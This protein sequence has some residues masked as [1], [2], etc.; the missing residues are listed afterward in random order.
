MIPQKTTNPSCNE[1]KN[2]VAQ[3]VEIELEAYLD[4]LVSRCKKSSSAS[5]TWNPS[6]PECS[7]NAEYT[8]GAWSLI[9]LQI[10]KIMH[11]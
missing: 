7:H 10:E 9:N 2:Y 11:Y 1:K 4:R 6:V 3:L 5:S 8:S